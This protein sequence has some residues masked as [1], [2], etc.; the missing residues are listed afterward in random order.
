MPQ[1]KVFIEP[2]IHYLSANLIIIVFKLRET[3]G[4]DVV[5]STIQL[6]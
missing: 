1:F 6:V 3:L 5:L 4:H 2:I